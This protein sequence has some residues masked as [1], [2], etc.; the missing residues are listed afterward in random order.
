MLGVPFLLLTLLWA[1]KEKSVDAHGRALKPVR[2]T[3]K[4]IL[5]S[6]RRL[7]LQGIGKDYLPQNRPFNNQTGISVVLGVP[8]F[9]LLFVGRHQSQSTPMDGR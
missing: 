2:R 9:C 4:P 8:F 7:Q 3:A 6:K 1:S 5:H